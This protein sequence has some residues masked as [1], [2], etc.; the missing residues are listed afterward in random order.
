MNHQIIFLLPGSVMAVLG[1]YYDHKRGWKEGYFWAGL[2]VCIL[3]GSSM[4]CLFLGS[5]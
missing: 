1:G 4:H 2:G 3:A 5:G